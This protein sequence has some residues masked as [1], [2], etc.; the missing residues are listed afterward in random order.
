M[1][2][3]VINRYDNNNYKMSYF[4][5]GFTWYLNDQDRNKKIFTMH[6]LAYI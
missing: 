6:L 4:I 5:S 3:L 1:K 2:N